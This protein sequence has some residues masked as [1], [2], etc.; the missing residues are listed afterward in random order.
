MTPPQLLTRLH[1]TSP[2]KLAHGGRLELPGDDEDAELGG[3]HAQVVAEALHALLQDGVVLLVLV[4]A[5]ELLDARQREAVSVRRRLLP[6]RVPGHRRD[7][8]CL[9]GHV[10]GLCA[11][12]QLA[13]AF[14][15][16]G[17]GL[18]L[19]PAAAAAAA[20]LVVSF[21][22]AL[23]VSALAAQGGGRV[24]ALGDTLAHVSHS[25]SGAVCDPWTPLLWPGEMSPHSPVAL[26]QSG[27]VIPGGQQEGRF[28][29]GDGVVVVSKPSVN[30]L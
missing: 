28:S 12:G 9:Q 22:A 29:T 1:L 21:G 25:A 26:G 24:L 13:G 20:L 17:A 23:L 15:A 5:E 8:G 11:I 14:A 30:K 27:G 2:C 18:L 7:H 6:V 19:V 10:R 3:V 4:A 16:Q